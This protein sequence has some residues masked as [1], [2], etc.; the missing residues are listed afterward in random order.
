MSMGVILKS[1][2]DIKWVAL[3]SGG[4]FY[5]ANGGGQGKVRIKSIQGEQLNHKSDYLA[6]SGGEVIKGAV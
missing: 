5:Y 6:E 2:G 3:S 4:S 1:W